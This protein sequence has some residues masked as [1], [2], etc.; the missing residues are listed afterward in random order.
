[1]INDKKKTLHLVVDPL[2]IAV[3][4]AIAPM[5]DERLAELE[6]KLKEDKKKS[7]TTLKGVDK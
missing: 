2:L 7:S 1:M 3:D 4:K 6:K 5:V